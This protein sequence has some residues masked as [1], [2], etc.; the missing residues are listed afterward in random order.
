MVEFKEFFSNKIFVYFKD[1]H[2]KVFEI[3]DEHRPRK[4][5]SSRKKKR[6]SQ[7]NG[8]FDTATSGTT[9]TNP[10]GRHYHLDMNTVPFIL[11]SSTTPSHNVKSNVQNVKL[12]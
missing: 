3:I 10:E 9:T 12:Y 2:E 1:Q 11:G 4:T 5:R 7:L 6:S 8:S